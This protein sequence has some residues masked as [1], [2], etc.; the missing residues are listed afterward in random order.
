MKKVNLYSVETKRKN[1]P[2]KGKSPIAETGRNNAS[3]TWRTI[4]MVYKLS[5]VLI[6][7]NMN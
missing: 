1:F 3:G 7:L 6:H 2:G 5:Q 4:Y